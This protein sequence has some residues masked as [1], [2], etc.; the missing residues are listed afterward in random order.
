MIHAEEQDGLGCAM[1]NRRILIGRLL[2]A[3]LARLTWKPRTAEPFCSGKEKKNE[4]KRTVDF[5]ACR[6]ENLEIATD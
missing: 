1:W 2:Y 5:A 6:T 4:A 3:A